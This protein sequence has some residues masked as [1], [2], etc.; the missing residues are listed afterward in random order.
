[1]EANVAELKNKGMVKDYSVSKSPEEYAFDNLNIRITPNRDNT[2]LSVTNEKGPV[3]CLVGTSLVKTAINR[4]SASPGTEGITVSLDNSAASDIAV[5]IKSSEGRISKIN[6]RSAYTVDW[7]KKDVTFEYSD[8]VDHY[9]Y[10]TFVSDEGAECNGHTVKRLYFNSDFSKLYSNSWGIHLTEFLDDGVRFIVNWMAIKD[11]NGNEKNSMFL[12]KQSDVR[13]IIPDGGREILVTGAYTSEYTLSL[14]D[15]VDYISD[16]SYYYMTKETYDEYVRKGKELPGGYVVTDGNLSGEYC[17]GCETLDGMVVFTNDNSVNSIYHIRYADGNELSIDIIY[18]GKLNIDASHRIEALFRFE[19]EDV[20]KV[21]WVDG[22]NQPRVVNIAAKVDKDKGDRQFDFV[23]TVD[24]MPRIDIR[25]EYNSSGLFPAGTIQYGVSY[26]NKFGSET[27]L[28]WL[29]TLHYVTFYDRGAKADEN[30]SCQFRLK[31]LNLDSKFDYVRVYSVLRTS[32]DAQPIVSIVGDY[33]ISGNKTMTVYDNNV[34][35]TNVDPSL[36]YYIG[37]SE[38]VASTMAQKQDRLFLGNIRLT[39]DTIST[40]LRNAV[41][42][43]INVIKKGKTVTINDASMIEYDYKSNGIDLSDTSYPYRIQTLCGKE[44]FS[45]FKYGETYRFAIQFQTN[46]GVWTQPLWIGDKKCTL[47]PKTDIVAGRVMLPTATFSPTEKLLAVTNDYSMYRVLIAETSAS[48]RNVIAQ[49]VLSPTVFSLKDRIYNSPYAV[50]SWVMR[51]NGDMTSRLGES[52]YEEIQSMDKDAKPSFDASEVGKTPSGESGTVVSLMFTDDIGKVKR[53]WAKQGADT[54]VSRLWH[55]L[56]SEIIGF[57]F[58]KYHY[59]LV[60]SYQYNDGEID[61]DS[62]AIHCESRTSLNKMWSKVRSYVMRNLNTDIANDISKSEF[63]ELCRYRRKT[64]N[65]WIELDGIDSGDKSLGYLK[66]LYPDRASYVYENYAMWGIYRK[67]NVVTYQGMSYSYSNKIANSG[68]F[69]DDSIVTFHSP[70]IERNHE[71]ID[72]S[73]L[74]MRIIGYVPITA[75]I[76]DAEIDVSTNGLCD[77]ADKISLQDN[78]W[79]NISDNYHTLR[80]A[81]LYSDSGWIRNDDRTYPSKIIDRYKIY[82]WHKSQSINGLADDSYP[83]E[84]GD[85]KFDYVP[86]VLN[87]KVFASKRFSMYDV[88]FENPLNVSISTPSVIYDDNVTRSV[89][90]CQKDIYYYGNVDSV[91][92]RRG[93]VTGAY[94][95]DTGDNGYD[96]EYEKQS[97]SEI[98][99]KS[100]D[101]IRIKYKSQDHVVFAMTD[102]SM[103]YYRL[104][105][106]GF[107]GTDTLPDGEAYPWV[108]PAWTVDDDYAFI[109]LFASAKSAENKLSEVFGSVYKYK[110]KTLVVA[111]PY[112]YTSKRYS[113]LYIVNVHSGSLSV[114]KPNLDDDEDTDKG[115][116]VTDIPMRVLRLCE[117]DYPYIVSADKDVVMLDDLYNISWRKDGDTI[118]YKQLS[119][120]GVERPNYPYLYLAE[121]YREIPYESLYGGYDTEQIKKLKWIVSSSPYPVGDHIPRMSGDTYYQRWD[122]LKTYPSSEEDTNS[123]VDITSFMVETHEM[124]DGRCDINRRNAKVTLARPENYNLFNAAYSQIDNIFSYN[125]LD[126]KY[127]LDMFGNQVVWSKSKVDT[128]IVDTWTDIDMLSSINLDGSKGDVRRLVNLNDTLVAFQD[129]AISVI[130]YNNPTQISTESGSPIEVVNSGL[131]NGYTMMTGSNGCQNKWSVCMGGNGVYFIDDLN[132]SM[133]SLGKDGLSSVSAKGFSQWFKDNIDINDRFNIY[134]DALTKDAYVVNSRFCLSF[135]EELDAFGS[136]YS[137][138]GMKDVFNIGGDTYSIGP[139]GSISVHRMFGGNYGETF[140]NAEAGW[141]VT[142]KANPEPMVDKV[143]TNIEYT[144]DVIDGSVDDVNYIEGL[145]LRSLDIW[146]EYQKGSVDF[147]RQHNALQRDNTRKFRLWRVQLPRD[148][149][150]RNRLD[151]IRNTWCYIKL[152]D[153]NPLGKK[154]VLHNVILK[155][156][157]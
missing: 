156:Y 21:Y 119:L 140:D 153:D 5:N 109:G 86:S 142:Y 134:Y 121:L 3:R 59:C 31:I 154:V 84:K 114:D 20:Q 147:T 48:T 137:Y 26:Y 38:F 24:R 29:S 123:V 54:N 148:E 80:N 44:Y 56:V 149:M 110:D 117:W 138:E 95:K 96:V 12:P 73:G 98:Y 71:F 87:R 40:A 143:F 136:F 32:L 81:F 69:V 103:T 22:V 23:P 53:Y 106:I 92:T 118:K 46:K 25:K 101:P 90:A 49:G 113:E 57:G 1:M 141:S 93:D 135:N 17:G 129:K 139:S 13:C 39:G 144:A 100:Y 127:D 64:V 130:N 79:N 6:V 150:S 36:L 104:P 68:Y 105:E 131:V 126:D 45:Y 111:I 51:A 58:A 16:G 52:A 27:G 91:L 76:N 60:L 128:D 62:I 35:V 47:R 28:L 102:N 67:L 133:L 75:G 55:Y 107:E 43:S 30:V 125:I 97:D 72:N 63:K 124:L 85:E 14:D 99:I 94:I 112:G 37:G 10:M 7:G 83:S 155:Y 157:K 15:N 65:N 4:I 108:E 11:S 152:S 89:K 2:G 42:D 88:F 41:N 18:S 66:L 82:M 132:K 78:I 9:G 115:Q 145:P 77:L 61:K 34:N 146:N 8:D 19:S 151:R 116:D 50:S 33:S 74:D 122:C 120:K 70:D